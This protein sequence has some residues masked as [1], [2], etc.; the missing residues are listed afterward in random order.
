MGGRIWSRFLKLCRWE[1]QT[2]WCATSV[3][4]KRTDFVAPLQVGA[5]WLCECERKNVLAYT[6]SAGAA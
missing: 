1:K 6:V 4:R 5:F 3:L 2:T